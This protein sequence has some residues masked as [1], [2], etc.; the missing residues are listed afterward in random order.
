MRIAHVSDIHIRNL[1]YH[2]EYRAAFQ[3][4]YRQLRELKP[5][6][7]VNTGDTAHTKV[8]I[9]PEFVNMASE[10]FTELG[11]IAPTIVIL[12]NHDL[13]LKNSDRLDAISPIINNVRAEHEVTLPL[14]SGHVWNQVAPTGSTSFRFWL[15]GI[16]DEHDHPR[17]GS[18]R[19]VDRIV[20]IGLFHGSVFGAVVDSGFELEQYEAKMERFGGMDFVLMGDI[21]KRQSFLG[22]RAWYA[23]SLIQQNFGEDPE[24]GFLVWD[25]RS[26]DDFDV[27]F[28]RIVGSRGFYTIDIGSDLVVPNLQI[29]IDARIRAIVDAELTLVQQ[30]DIE[31]ELRRRF[32]PKDVVSIVSRPK[33]PIARGSDEEFDPDEPY[34]ERLEEFVRSRGADDETVSLIKAIDTECTRATE[35]EED[36]HPH[37]FWR[38]DKIAWS[39]LFNYG[40]ANLIDMS[41]ARGLVGIFAPNAS[42]KSSIFDVVLQ[43]LFDKVS[44]DVPRNIDLINDNRDLATMLV[45]MTVGDESYVVER[46]IERIKYGQRKFSEA[47]EWGKTTLNLYRSTPEGKVEVNENGMSRPET[48]RQI[49][50]LIGSFE[51]FVMTSMVS[52]NPIFGVPGGS[53]I[54][55]CKET[56]RKKFLF[57]FLG[58]DSFEVKVEAAKDVLKKLSAE[59]KLLDGSTLEEQLAKADGL[60]QLFESQLEGLR[61]VIRSSRED[62]TTVEKMLNEAESAKLP[63][64]PD[65]PEVLREAISEAERAVEECNRKLQADSVALT[66]ASEKL[67]ELRDSQ[68]PCPPVPLEELSKQR[69]KLSQKKMMA[70]ADADRKMVVLKTARKAS[71][72]IDEVPCEGEYPT[73]KFLVD[74]FAARDKLDDLKR[75]Y[76]AAVATEE[77]AVDDLSE[78]NELLVV[79]ERHLTWQKAVTLCESEISS[80]EARIALGDQILKARLDDLE[81]AGRALQASLDAEE[82]RRRVSEKKASVELLRARVATFKREI[83]EMERN[84][85][86]LTRKA[87]QAE[88][89]ADRIRS[90]MTR[91]ERLRKQVSAYEL[92]VEAMG[93]HG[94]PYLILAGMLPLINEE[95]NKILANVVDFGVYIEHDPYEQTIRIYLQYGEYKSRPLGLCSGAEKFV[96]LLAI[97]A[98]LIS[99][100]RLPKTNVLIIDEGFGKL[101]PERLDAV[102]R[103]LEYMKTIFGSVFIISHVDALKDLVDTSVEITVDQDGYAHVEVA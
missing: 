12:G 41:L 67:Q 47:K 23:G 87:G 55:N 73:C 56:D 94:I 14:T 58:L 24:K 75:A 7:I 22:G 20:D 50:R 49:R 77:S 28:H 38:I 17:P 69:E 89:D 62:Q 31:R 11:N 35:D 76:E 60:S 37:A 81:R 26:A 21:H 100:S 88:A 1:R 97:R 64:V 51:D 4:L 42:G 2:D 16:T 95:I 3:D 103:M 6:L 40:E 54:I 84:L 70:K 86:D 46:Q 10:F 78:A 93:K 92:Y 27:T 53:D 63:D 13:N 8:Q 74:A 29:P 19:K 85:I 79:G 101:D 33:Q 48:E 91:L 65:D 61:E 57:R 59:M 83:S 44:K 102:Q 5:D 32:R 90:D 34:S 52:Q 72:T 99:V 98:A 15:Y 36:S 82:E 9:S 30:K 25:I 71:D 66:E 18:I 43:S 96:A 45:E 68:P 80:L 39:N